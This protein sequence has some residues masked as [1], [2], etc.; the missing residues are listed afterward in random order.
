M[1]Y[2]RRYDHPKHK[3]HC[4]NI[5]KCQLHKLVETVHCSFLASHITHVT[6]NPVIVQYKRLKTDK[7]LSLLDLTLC[8]NRVTII[9]AHGKYSNHWEKLSD[10]THWGMNWVRVTWVDLQS[11]D[12]INCR[13]HHARH[14]AVSLLAESW[15][16]S[17]A[18]CLWLSTPVHKYRSY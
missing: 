9:N 5:S 11:K 8:R 4:S 14:C 10:L 13:V 17:S 12:D 16:K 7:M 1:K 15:D 18:F 6:W 3:C 2:L